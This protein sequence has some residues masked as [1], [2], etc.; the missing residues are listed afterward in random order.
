M[1]VLAII[2]KMGLKKVN[3]IVREEDNG[4]SNCFFVHPNKFDLIEEFVK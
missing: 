4:V 1:Y 3:T 2:L